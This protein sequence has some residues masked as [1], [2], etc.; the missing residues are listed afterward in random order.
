MKT[1]FK[2]LTLAVALTAT[3]LV[4]NN[5]DLPA[6]PAVPAVIDGSIVE[7]FRINHFFRMMAAR[8]ALA[9][10]HN[11]NLQLIDNLIADGNAAR[12]RWDDLNE[13]NQQQAIHD[14][15]QPAHQ[16]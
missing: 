2:T 3:T 7:L 12:H 6:V 16:E 5:N 1:L 8:R 4:A 14:Q 9:V 13:G 15:I 10:Q 11:E